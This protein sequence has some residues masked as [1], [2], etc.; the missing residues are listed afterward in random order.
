MRGNF[1]FFFVNDVLALQSDRIVNLR[2]GTS[3]GVDCYSAPETMAHFGDLTVR[4]APTLASLAAARST[5]AAVALSLSSAGAPRRTY[6]SLPGRDRQGIHLRH[7]PRR[8]G[9]FEPRLNSS[10]G[11]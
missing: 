2:N 8:E 7:T 11:R 4:E 1:A 6:G 10:P 5:I 9:V 3:F